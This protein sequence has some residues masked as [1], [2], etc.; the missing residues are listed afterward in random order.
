MHIKK[1]LTLVLILS[2]A[3]LSVAQNIALQKTVTVSSVENNSL[4]GNLAVD[5][6]T[7]TR[8]GSGYSD[9]QTLTV[10][11]NAVYA[12]NRVVIKWEASY[13]THYQIQL[14]TDEQQWITVANVTNGNGNTDDLNFG[15]QNARYVRMYGT[16]RTT[17]GNAQYGYSIYEFEVY[18]E[19]AADDASLAS[20]VV[21]G[22][23]LASFSSDQ[24]SY[25]YTLQPGNTAIPSV[26]ATPTNTN[27]TYTITNTQT[28]PGTTT[29]TVTSA[30]GTKT[31]TYSIAFQQSA[32]SLVWS[33]EFD[34][35]GAVDA[36]KWFHQ[37]YP[38]NNGSWFNNEEQH[39]TNQLSNSSVDNGTLK[40]TA[41][42][43]SY[44]DPSTGSTKQYT[45]ARLNSKYAFK[46]GRVEVRAKLPPAQGTWPAIWT[47]GKN[48]SETGAYWQTQGYGDTSWPF[49][50]EIDIMEQDTNKSKTSGAFHFPDTSGNHTYTYD[51]IDVSDTGNTWHVYAMEWTAE[52]ISL[53]VDGVVFHSLNNSQN[54]YFDNEHFILLNIAMGGG[55]GGTIPASFTSS[56]MEIDYVRVYQIQPLALGPLEKSTINLYPNPAKDMLLIAAP[57][58]DNI[59][60]QAYDL[61][62]KLLLK[63]KVNNSLIDVSSFNAGVYLF[64]L[65]LDDTLVVKKVIIN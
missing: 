23:D 50:G 19:A 41:I 46:Y 26:T 24:Y 65:R 11:L 20:I 64:E 63:R 7:S 36:S 52:S 32:Y 5:G 9:P 16:Q 61:H 51:T 35:A 38:P 29:I 22:T 59:H 30:D 18:G 34:Y 13:A 58:V 54:P 40:I 17:I 4:N 3:F 48:I 28:I 27:A 47:L 43:E 39:Y 60:V 57:R 21:N 45:S 33:D 8:W 53:M 10:D 6:N 44:E 55:L 1:T 37:T 14:S 42:K 49:C 56:I 12:V 62:G 25:E 15:A 31:K 2:V